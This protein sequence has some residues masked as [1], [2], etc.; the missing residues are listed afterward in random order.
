MARKELADIAAGR[1]SAAQLAHNFDDVAPP[2]DRQGALLAAARC[3]YCFDAPCIQACPTGIDIPTFIRGISTDNLRGAAEEILGANILGGMCARVCPTE[4]LC[5]GDCVR[6]VDDEQPVQIGA[7][8]RYATDWVY[9]DNATLF[10]RAPE[11]GKRIAVIG[12]GPAGLSCAHQLARAGHRVTI[13]DANAKPGGLNEY[14]IAA[15]KVPGFAQREVEWL[16]SIGGIEL[17][18]GPALGRELTLSQ[19]RRDFDAVFLGM[20]LAGVNALELEGEQL[21]GVRN[22]V[23]FIAE[24]R[25]HDNLTTLP[26]GRRVVVIGGGNTAIDAAIQSKRLGA[27]TVTLVYRRGAEA[28]SATSHEQAFAKSEGVNVI[29]WA[30]PRRLLGKDGLLAGIEFEYTQLNEAGKLMGSG[31]VF[32]LAADSVLKAIGQV[33]VPAPLDADHG[34]LLEI[35]DGRIAVNADYATSLPGVWAGGDCVGG[36][37]DL[38]VQ[39]VEDGKQAALA[40]D[41]ALRRG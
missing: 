9:R 10:E 5:E 30:Q 28:M 6:N 25:Q 33:L 11:T 4:I 39:A 32:T 1:L 7:L 23:E 13:Y 17:H 36:K 18:C 14:G 38:T 24:L 35:K 20:G 40:I 34:E 16:M 2:L 3:Y 22:A 21:P 26:I 19:L 37:T 12:A 31:D 27:E 41:R 8:Q 29:H 15:Y